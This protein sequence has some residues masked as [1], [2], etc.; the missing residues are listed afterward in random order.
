MPFPIIP[1]ITTALSLASS[2]SAKAKAKKAEKQAEDSTLPTYRQNKSILDYYDT[3]LRRY[4]TNT[5]DTSEYKLQKQLI[6]QGTVQGLSSLNKLRSGN[7]AGLIN[8]Q[9]NALLK[10]EVAGEQRK[11]R[12]LDVLGRA[13]GMKANEGA[14]EFQYNQ[15]APFEKTYNLLTAK[16]GGY[17]QVQNAA[18]QNAYNNAGAAA[19]IMAGGN[20]TDS[21]NWNSIFGTKGQKSEIRWNKGGQQWWQN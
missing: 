2:A 16:A 13:T 12:D 19:S 1:L 18:I 3:A 17:R 8:G 15:V 9:N 7:V 6:N 20:G 4:N 21:F 10:A 5:A 14:K 11:A